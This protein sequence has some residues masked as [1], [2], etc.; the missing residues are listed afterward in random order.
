M[1]IQ[2]TNS[3][4]NI[5]FQGNKIKKTPR[6]NKYEVTHLART[7]GGT[8]GL[9]SGA[10]ASKILANQMKTVS[11]KKMFINSLHNIG[12]DLTFLGPSKNRTVIKKGLIA[13]SATIS[14]L[15]MFVGA[16]IGGTI[17]SHN[18][19]K[20]AKAADKAAKENP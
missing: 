16:A 2:L 13:L 17:D 19:Q 8:V 14:L 9:L 1:S 18:N 4:N 20:R 7:T 6:G 11:G 10:L 15:G 12:K 3:A 5:T